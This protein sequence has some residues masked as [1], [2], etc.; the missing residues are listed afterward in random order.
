MATAKQ[1]LSLDAAK[2]QT[3]GMPQLVGTQGTNFPI[4]GEYAFDGTSVERLFLRFQALNYGSGNIT[5]TVGWYA[6]TATS[7]AVVWE[8]A[9]AAMTPNT[10]SASW[11]TKAF[12]TVNT[13]ADTHLGTTAKR[14]H[15]VDIAASNVDSLAENDWVVLRISRLPTDAGDTMSGDAIL[16][17][18]DIAYSDT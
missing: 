14:P 4:I 5:I 13:Q 9:I 3:S 1:T 2:L 12:A 10:D 6:A 18:V 8:S 16:A 17:S 15:T 11:E 7:G